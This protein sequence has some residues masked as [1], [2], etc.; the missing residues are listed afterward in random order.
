MAHAIS[1]RVTSQT[2]VSRE[3]VASIITAAVGEGPLCGV[4]L[5]AGVVEGRPPSTVDVL[6]ADGGTCR[7]C[8]AEW[9]QSG[10]SPPLTRSSTAYRRSAAY[11]G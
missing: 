5:E 3:D 11:G 6:A 7:Y 9:V 10:P 4:R 2:H 1:N 8:L